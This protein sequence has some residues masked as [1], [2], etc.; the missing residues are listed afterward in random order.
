[1]SW[2]HWPF[3]P[4]SLSEMIGPIDGGDHSSRFVSLFV[5]G[6]GKQLGRPVTILEPELDRMGEPL[7]EPDPNKPGATRLKLRRID[8]FNPREGF[9]RFCEKLREYSGQ[10]DTCKLHEADI[11]C[12]VF[13]AALDNLDDVGKFVQGYPCH[14]NLV[15]QAGVI[16]YHQ[17]PVAVILSGQF[18][19]DEDASQKQV[20]KLIKKMSVDGILT[21]KQKKDLYKHVRELET[22][23]NFTVKFICESSPKKLSES[24]SLENTKPTASELFLKVGRELEQM[25]V[26]QFQ[27]YKRDR[28]SKFLH[29]LRQIFPSSPVDNR[30]SI[31]DKMQPILDEVLRFCGTKYL[32]LFI[33]PQRYISYEGNPNLLPLFMQS[34]IEDDVVSGIMHFNW[35][36]FNSKFTNETDVS[37]RDEISSFYQ[38]QRSFSASTQSGAFAILKI[39]IKGEKAYY[40]KDATLVCHMRLS[41]AYQAVLIWGSFARMDTFD[42]EQEVRFLEEIS[43]LV[44]MRILSSVQLSDSDNRTIAWEDVAGLLS[45]YSR[46][47]MNPVSTGVRIISDYLRNGATFSRADAE[48]ACESLETASRVISQSVRSP[49]AS[50]AATSEKVYVFTLASLEKIVRDSIALYQPMALDKSV[51]IK[52]DTSVAALPLVEV[53]ATKMEAAIGNVLE[54]A[55]KYSHR[56][57]EIR[58]YGERSEEDYVRLIVEDFGQGIKGEDLKL[59]FKR[60]YQ[61]G[62]SRKALYEEGEGLGLF[63][64]RLIVDAHKGEIWC[65]CQ[66]GPRTEDSNMLEGYRVRFTFKL[67]LKAIRHPE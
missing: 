2:E 10:D 17:K 14:M 61:G 28:E 45:H 44:M 11:G 33:S 47:A 43:E 7:K 1:M 27:M 32:A 9:T 3:Y 20:Y 65:S 22:R 41:D 63:H 40:F 12:Q 57:K 39:S 42:V 51:T 64:T 58:I 18:L 53:D 34:G 59:I 36:K 6:Y 23:D 25:A 26:A 4:Q 35:R 60:Y 19:P 5:S 50:F 8:E 66:S 62:R 56:N 46:R 24:I 29:D 48:A 37:K 15:Y 54:N 30:Q 38:L 16:R 31:V 13:Q 67:P 52:V 49:L 21:D 55:I